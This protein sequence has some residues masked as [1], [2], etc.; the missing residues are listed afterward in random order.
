MGMA[1]KWF[2]KCYANPV[3][4]TSG[5]IRDQIGILP[6]CVIAER[7]RRRRQIEL[8]FKWIKQHLCIK[9]LFGTS[10]RAVRP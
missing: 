2:Q 9:S 1:T 10:G 4:W 7:Y 5:I 8:F 6:T 3:G